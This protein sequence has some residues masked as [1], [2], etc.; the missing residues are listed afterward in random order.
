MAEL[1]VPEEEEK[2]HADLIQECLERERG[3]NSYR[4]KIREGMEAILTNLRNISH[5][6]ETIDLGLREIKGRFAEINL[7]SWPVLK[8]S[9]A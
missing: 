4:V 6:M 7:R 8:L 2:Q 9:K 5:T 3:L 1:S